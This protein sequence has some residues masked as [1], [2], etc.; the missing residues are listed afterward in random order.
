[1]SRSKCLTLLKVLA[2]LAWADGELT[3]SEHNVLKNLYRRFGLAQED[4]DALKPYL[5]GPVSK[6]EQD[7]L[8][9]E[10]AV[11][12]GSKKHRR[13]ALAALE[14][15]AAADQKLKP[16]EKALLD[17]CRALLSQSN[18]TRRSFGKIR[19]FFRRTL[20]PPVREKNP[21]LVRYFQDLV[22]HQLEV[23]RG[24]RGPRFPVEDDRFYFICLLGTLLARVAE[25][26]G[27]FDPAEQRALRDLLRER[28]RLEDD[29]W[30]L[31]LEVIG[32]Q[33]R[34]G[35]DFDEVVR[36]FNRVTPYR[37]RL[38]CV[39]CF[40]TIAAADGDMSYE[41]VEEIRRITKALHVPHKYFIERKLAARRA[42]GRS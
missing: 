42:M 28:Y 36:E 41:E 17:H 22:Y 24:G 21:E 18:F 30:R 23:R 15:M 9:Q 8:F 31:L 38:L 14:E 39:D 5:R 13:E 11:E 32:E 1:M 16:Q 37:D 19:N 34:K 7:A 12:M 26:D 4:I 25:A 40:F 29:Q 33:A 6:K 2:T 27:R 35:F 20:F 3:N 10:L